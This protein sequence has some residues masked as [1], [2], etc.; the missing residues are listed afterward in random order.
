MVIH[1]FFNYK[2]CMV[3][4]QLMSKR[5][6]TICCVCET[7]YTC[8]R[9]KKNPHETHINWRQLARNAYIGFQHKSGFKYLKIQIKMDPALWIWDHAI[10]KPYLCIKGVVLLKVYIKND[11]YRILFQSKMDPARKKIGY[12]RDSNW[13]GMVN[14]HSAKFERSGESRSNR[15][16]P[17]STRWKLLLPI[18]G[19]QSLSA[20][21]L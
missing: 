12:K 7:H 5:D 18:P 14:V 19:T 1:R 4:M 16:K 2:Q 21:F 6:Y 9:S 10:C 15:P 8:L 11:V 3:Y 20:Q 17:K 13:V